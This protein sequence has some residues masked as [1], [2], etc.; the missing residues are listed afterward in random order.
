VMFEYRKDYFE[1]V[2]INVSKEKFAV[3]KMP[4]VLLKSKFHNQEN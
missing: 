3:Q 4:F 2:P 1:T